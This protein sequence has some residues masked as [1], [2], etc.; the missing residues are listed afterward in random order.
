MRK[1]KEIPYFDSEL[2]L[3]QSTWDEG[4]RSARLAHRNRIGG[5]N[6]KSPEIPMDALFR[7]FIFA[8]ENGEFSEVQ[9]ID[10]LNRLNCDMD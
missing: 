7:L 10:L 9:I 2:Q 4:E 3:G 6:M 5:F 8:L 1:D